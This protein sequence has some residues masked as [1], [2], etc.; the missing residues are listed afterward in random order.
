MKAPTDP[1]AARELTRIAGHWI[2]VP[3]CLG[4]LVCLALGFSILR[5]NSSGLVAHYQALAQKS[6]DD[7]DYATAA[8]ASLRLMGFGEQY[9]NEALL[10]LAQAKIGLGQRAEAA[11]L[12]EMVGDRASNLEGTTPDVRPGS[13]N[14]TGCFPRER[15]NRSLPR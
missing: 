1:P 8:V 10:Q 6:L 15:G 5:P 4:I 7:H 9:R 14:S 2:R 12:L 3:A 13:A 11:N